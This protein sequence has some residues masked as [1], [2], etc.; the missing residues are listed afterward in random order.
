[1][2]DHFTSNSI[3]DTTIRLLIILLIITWCLLILYPFT[4]ILLWSLILAMAMHPLHTKI[5]AKL[6]GR[7]KLAS[8]IIV[9]SVMII[10]FVPLWF[11]IDSLINEV[12]ILKDSYDASGF[13]ISAP[14]EKV[15]EWP[16]VG[17]RVYAFW[18]SASVNLEQTFLTYREQLIDLGRKLS[19]G[20]ISSVSAVIQIMVS[21]IIA[22]ILLVFG[23][24]GESIRK[25]YRKLAGD[26]GDEFADLT[27]MTVGSVVKGV[28]GVALIMAFLYGILLVL[29]G[30]PY[31]GLLIILMF[32]LQIL[33]ISGLIVVL[34]V[35]VYLFA[36]REPIPAI[37]WSILLFAVGM[38][39]NI[40][41]PILLGKGSPVPMPVIYIGVIGG[42]IFSG[43]IGLFTGAIIMSLGY[44]LFIGWLN[45]NEDVKQ[46]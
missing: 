16:V 13:S 43:F 27:M 45:S 20:I 9:I 15:K 46:S 38:V 34:P 17:A 21:F 40:L 8:I 41:R 3:Y 44:K 36:V 33:Q 29:A 5:A 31:A 24:I 39:D 26:R 25:F 11:L 10:I 19:K 30:I 12:K 18:E 35:V 2:K 1:M 14:T 37:I 42:F 4:S 7:L 6:G 22:A 23:G 28:I 32:V